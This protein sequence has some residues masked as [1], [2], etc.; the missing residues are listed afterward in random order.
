MTDVVVGILNIYKVWL[1]QNTG[2]KKTAMHHTQW[3]LLLTW[4]NF[5]LSMDK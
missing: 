5:N 2:G 3:P 1:N 4:I